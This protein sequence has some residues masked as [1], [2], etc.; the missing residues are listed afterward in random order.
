[1]SRIKNVFEILKKQNKKALIP[2]ITAGYPETNITV[3]LMHALVK[4]GADIIELGI[5]FSDPMADGPVIQRASERALK[6][7]VYL[8]NVLRYV[9]EFRQKN[10]NT[11][12]VLMGYANPIERMGI[13][14]FVEQSHL[15]GV[16]GA[17]IVDYPP[18][19][20]ERFI[21]LM[22]ARDMDVIFLLAPTSNEKRIKQVGKIATG[23]IYYVSLKGVTG[24]EN[25]D[26]IQI[27]SNIPLI[28]KHISIPISV[29]FGI[30][31]KKIAKAV[32]RLVDGIVIGSKLIQVIENK[33]GIQIENSAEEFI[34]DFRQALDE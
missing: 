3:P 16:D 12:I 5:P 8:H 30:R 18:E 9:Q 23:Y 31:D 24:S 26:L 15:S 34:S 29:G 7:Q 33:E 1:M 25:L 20:S 4:G 27:S 13:E 21:S 28:K 17:L 6:N 11:P 2:F 32:S 22:K 14:N 19:E 10:V